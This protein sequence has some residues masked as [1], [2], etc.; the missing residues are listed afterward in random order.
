MLLRITEKLMKLFY[1]ELE[2]LDDNNSTNLKELPHQNKFFESLQFIGVDKPYYMENNS[3]K[4][5]SFTGEDC[6]NILGKL[7]FEFFFPQDNYPLFIKK[8]IFNILLREFNEIFLNIKM[9]YYVENK[10]ILQ[11]KTDDW[12]SSYTTTFHL[13]HVTGYIHMFAHHL[14]SCLLR[15]TGMLTFSIAKELKK[16]TI[17]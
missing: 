17:K 7:D 2:I 8:D 13:K 12:L 11:K 14:C 15:N 16:E 5:K 10:N 1:A 4:L 9:N 3:Y 6:L